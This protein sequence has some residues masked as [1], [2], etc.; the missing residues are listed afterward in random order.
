MSR[1][2]ALRSATLASFTVL[3]ASASAQIS[4]GVSTTPFTD[5]FTSGTVIPGVSDD[6]EH[7]IGAVQLTAA[8]YAGNGLLGAVD[9]RIGNNGAVLWQDSAADEVGYVNSTTFPTMVADNGAVNGNGGLTPG[10][11]ML[12]PDWDD[13]FPS[14]AAGGNNALRWQVIGGNLIIQWSNED[15]FNAQGAGTVQYELIAYGGVS[16]G[17]GA[18]LVDFV[19][20]DTLYAS[21]AYQNDGGSATIGYK[22]WGSNP[23]AN[24]V[25]FG[26]GGGTNSIGD[27]P[28]GDPSMKPKVGGY[29]AN[30]DPLLPHG[31][32]IF[33]LPTST[34]YCTA[35]TNSQSCLPVIA[36][37]GLPSATAGAGFVVSTTSVINNKPGLYIYTS[38]GRAAVPL[39]GG[40]RCIGTPIKFGIPLNAG[41][42]PPPNNCSGVYSMDFNRFALGGLGGL[43][44]AFLSVPGTL[45]DCQAWGRDNGFPPPNNATLSGGLEWTIGA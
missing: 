26:T 1:T 22:N 29:L 30:N 14:V 34:V 4:I 11:S 27:P 43:P 16:I 39:S 2:F 17:S 25:E 37:V 35:K 9:I 31:V 19:Y 10:A 41:G 20:N 7:F 32:R 18:T 38:G 33:G 12:C 8:G 15:H 44:A 42:N 13:N 23:N 40:L 6:S 5:I 28:F 24:D 45:V 21:G 36:S 3:A